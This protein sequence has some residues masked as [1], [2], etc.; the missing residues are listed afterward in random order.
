MT[1]LYAVHFSPP[2]QYPDVRGWADASPLVETWRHEIPN[3]LFLASASSAD[4]LARDLGARTGNAGRVLI[5]EVA[6][7][8]FAGWMSADFWKLVQ[9]KA[10]GVPGIATSE[11]TGSPN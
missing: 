4:E 2:I 8:N 9:A 1:R 3:C 6:G 5:T 7:T 10:S 11:L